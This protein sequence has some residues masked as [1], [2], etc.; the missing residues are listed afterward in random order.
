MTRIQQLL[1]ERNLRVTD[2]AKMLDITKQ[3]AYTKLRNP[4]VKSLRSIAKALEVPMWQLFAA[5]EEIGSSDNLIALIH[6]RGRSHT[7]TTVGEVMQ[8]LMEWQAEEFHKECQTRNF[9]HIREAYANDAEV[10]EAM[11]SL[12]SL[13]HCK[14]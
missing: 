6:Y 5:P 8:L 3:G 4:T 9:D 14:E 13:L 10:M 12:C 11:D 2:L 1:K 7:P